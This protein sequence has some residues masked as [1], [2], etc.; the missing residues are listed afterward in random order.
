MARANLFTMTRNISN[1]SVSHPDVT[2]VKADAEK[3][4]PQQVKEDPEHV[5][6]DEP[7]SADASN[8]KTTQPGPAGG[9]GELGVDNEAA[10]TAGA[11]MNVSDVNSNLTRDQNGGADIDKLP[12]KVS[13]KDGLSSSDIRTSVEEHADESKEGGDEA[14][15]TALKSIDASGAEE[16]ADADDLVMDLD[17]ETIEVT[18]MTDV[19]EGK[20][21]ELDSVA[22]KADSLSKATATVERYHGLLT[23][24]H[25]NGRFMSDEL[26]QSISWALESIDP[27]MFIVERVALES[28]NPTSRVSMEANELAVSNGRS[29]GPSGGRSGTIDDGADPGEVSKGLGGKLK[30]MF[31]AGMKIFWRTVNMVV[32]LI[33]EWTSDTGKLR[34]HLK[35]MHSRVKVLEGDKPFKLKGSSRLAIGDEFVGDSRNAIAKVTTVSKELLMVWPSA[36]AKVIEDWKGARGVFATDGGAAMGTV[37]GSLDSTIDRAFRSF[38]SLNPGDKDKVPSGFLD[39][40]RLHWSG[41]L[42]GNM[43]LYAGIKNAKG[44]AHDAALQDAQNAVKID[45]SLI[46]GGDSRAEGIEVVTPSAGEAVAIIRELE[47]LLQFVGDARDGMKQLKKF[48]DSAYSSAMGDLFSARGGIEGQFAG[49][50]VINLAKTATESQRRFIGYLLNLIKAYVGYLETSLKAEAGNGQT[51]DA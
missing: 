12:N 5:C 50:I 23:K 43:A 13:P 44:A 10:L 42:P 8:T 27:D 30:A 39:V 28:Y 4:L 25:N 21:A 37:I 6:P 1:E 49:L 48:S 18:G 22:A 3:E 17:D 15:S 33:A 31:E 38:D 46:P 11:H 24:M 14:E 7:I 36:M 32:D 41:P 20:L 34:D 40:E 51:L 9:G 2:N 29:S 19:T 47:K 45:F 35:A 26:R 16:V